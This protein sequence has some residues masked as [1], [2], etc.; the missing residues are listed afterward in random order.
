MLGGLSWARGRR[1]FSAE[2]SR[3]EESCKWTWGATYEDGDVMYEDV[4]EGGKHEMICVTVDEDAGTMDVLLPLNDEWEDG[5]GR[6]M[7]SRRMEGR[8]GRG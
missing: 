4:L 1:V 2:G 6:D 3:R 5:T 7:L 8:G